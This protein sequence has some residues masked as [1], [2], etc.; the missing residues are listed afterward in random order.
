MFFII[1]IYSALLHV[2]IPLCMYAFMH[3]Q[4]LS[5]VQFFATP[6]ACPSP[7]C[8]EFSMQEYWSYLSFPPPGDFPSSETELISGASPALAG[9]FITTVSPGKP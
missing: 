4:W 8:M 2:C 3:A 5:H 6:V 1:L 7:L 9:R